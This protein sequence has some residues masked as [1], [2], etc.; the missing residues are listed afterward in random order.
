MLFNVNRLNL[1]ITVQIS[2]KRTYIIRQAALSYLHSIASAT[3]QILTILI[4]EDATENAIINGIWVKL[5][6]EIKK[7]SI[8]RYRK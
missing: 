8:L 3:I 6:Y 7:K 1:I 4:K 5:I 2:N